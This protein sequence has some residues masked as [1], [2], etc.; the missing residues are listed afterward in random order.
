MRKPLPAAA[1]GF[2]HIGGA[3]YSGTRDPCVQQIR[4]WLGGMSTECPNPGICQ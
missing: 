2:E 1:G 4:A 3:I